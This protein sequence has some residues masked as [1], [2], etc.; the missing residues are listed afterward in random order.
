MFKS[1]GNIVAMPMS[2]CSSSR[3]MTSARRLRVNGS[4][5]VSDRDPLLTETVGAQ[6][7]VRVTGARSFR[8]VR[9]ISHD[10]FD[11]TSIYVPIAGRKQRS[12]LERALQISRTA[13][14]HGNRPL[15]GRCCDSPVTRSPSSRPWSRLRAA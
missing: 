3:C 10:E 13:S 1:L 6:L 2:A 11:R 8:I 9:A 14:I 12:R 4:A 15:K 5:S 7:I